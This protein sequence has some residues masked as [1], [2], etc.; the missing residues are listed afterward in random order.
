VK[1]SVLK[2]AAWRYW[3]AG[4]GGLV[5]LNGRLGENPYGAQCVNI[6]NGL[7]ED[8]GV[9]SLS[10]NAS[11][12][13]GFSD[14]VRKWVRSSPGSRP[15]V[16][17]AFVMG[18]SGGRPDGHTGVVLDGSRWPFLGMGQNSPTGSGLELCRY[19]G[20][21]VAGYIRLR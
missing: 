2:R 21:D 5:T 11:E 7:W 12:W 1:R 8:L 14:D 19:F 3:W 15:H 20:T 6:P 18:A 10:G 13:V 9:G 17:D 16:G 4:Q